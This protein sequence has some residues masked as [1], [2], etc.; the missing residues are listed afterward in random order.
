MTCVLQEIMLFEL[1]VVKNITCR[2]FQPSN[3]FV[4]EPPSPCVA[5]RFNYKDL[6]GV[7]YSS[8]QLFSNAFNRREMSLLLDKNQAV[9]VMRNR[10][11]KGALVWVVP[12]KSSSG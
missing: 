11:N 10:T 2:W 8:L 1:N 5:G 4:K 12:I 9:H 3:S 7:S 6:W